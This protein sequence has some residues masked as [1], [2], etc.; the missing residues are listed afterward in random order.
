MKKQ[1]AKDIPLCP[2]PKSKRTTTRLRHK[3]EKS[4]AAKQRKQRKLAKKNPEWRSKLKKDP[5]IPNS[6]PF[7]EK[8][9]HQIEEHRLRRQEEAQR[10]REQAKAA[11][12]GVL[13]VA[14][15]G[16]LVV[17]VVVVVGGFL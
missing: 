11:K 17:V 10:R 7:K 16:L 5:G 4:S 8:L 9:L 3:I 6:F 12:T 1:F 15:V 2:E 14:V 13:S